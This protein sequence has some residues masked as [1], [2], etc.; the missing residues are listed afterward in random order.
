MSTSH[1]ITSVGTYLAVFAALF[2]GTIVTVWIA[3]FD[4]GLLNVAIA[5]SIAIA[6]ASLVVWYFMGVR[7]NTP[8]TKVVVVA[9]L[10]WLLIMFGLGMSDYGSRH[11]LGVPGR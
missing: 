6:K 3:Y 1:P 2:V 8:L 4:F 11:W 5:L 10:F 9:G 7:Y